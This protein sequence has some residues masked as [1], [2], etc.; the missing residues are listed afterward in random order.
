MDD[1][2]RFRPPLNQIALSVIDLRVT[3][4][5]FREGFGLLPSGG[6]RLLTRGAVASRIQGLPSVASTVWW[7]VGK[8]PWAQLELFQFESPIA[9]LMPVDTRPCD[10]G[11]RRIGLWV[12]D[13]DAT[14]ANLARLGT[15][16]LTD[17][18]GPRGDRR[19]CVRSPDGVFV[20]IMER[21]PLPAL[22]PTGRPDCPVAV[23]SVS[24]SVPD[25][26]KS[27]SFFG[28]TLSADEV[29]VPLHTPE[30][31]ALWGLGGAKTK[32]K[33]FQAGDVLLEIVQYADPVGRPWPEGYRVSDQ[34]ILNIALGARNKRDHLQVYQR[35][36][37]AGAKPNSAPVHL[38]PLVAGGVVY[39]NDEQGFS[40]EILWLGTSRA[41][42]D[43][44]FDPLPI[45]RRPD[46]DTHRIEHTVRIAAPITKVWEA[47]ADHE[48]MSAWS[49]FKGVK[50]TADGV[51]DRRGRGAERWMKGPAGAI[52]EQVVDW[53]PPHSM[54]Y[55]VIQGSPLVCHQGEIRL[56]P[57]G[58]E[59]EVTWTIRF[60]SKVPGTGGLLRAVLN[61]GLRAA[62]GNLQALLEA[63]GARETHATD[64]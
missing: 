63:S 28:S 24:L 48:G 23:R 5:W 12:A 3:E 53:Q 26:V 41:N 21:D 15:S 62:L 52:A 55:R 40:V 7:L 1:A 33:V 56:A 17:P 58:A 61:R 20:E 59:T 8:N 19:A 57:A 32:S 13:F 54:R 36:C 29:D 43:W 6:G 4:R 49:G 50:Q 9:K 14:L 11:Y 31:E 39:V 22:A 60:R 38:S 16:P 44:G 64:A 30:H 27:A 46:P 10:I 18:L 37:A 35:A 25:L 45:T 34:G 2:G 47:F 42:R 51:P